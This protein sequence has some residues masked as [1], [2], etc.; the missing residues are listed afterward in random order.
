MLAV[1]TDDLETQKK[2]RAEIGASFPF[3]A[4]PQAKLVELY[5]VKTPVVSYA[6]RT[7]F[8][9]DKSRKVVSVT[10][11]GDAVDPRA[12]VDAAT[13]ACGG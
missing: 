1:S 11:G 4:D 5:D 7:T 3:V 8:V 9:I 6:K 2:F 13:L 12:A 10:T